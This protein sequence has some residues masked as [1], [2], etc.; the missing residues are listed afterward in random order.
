MNLPDKTGVYLFKN[1]RG[2][3]IYVGKALSLRNRVRS[4]FQK[5]RHGGPK[6][7]AMVGH[8][9]EVDYIVTGSEVEAL[10]L[11]NSL[12]KQY[13]PRYN[14]HLKDDKDYPYLKL[15]LE[16]EY[17]RLVLTRKLEKDGSRYFGP[18]TNV[19]A[20]RSTLKT[21]KKIFP[22]RSCQ[23]EVSPGSKERP[24]LN[25]HMHYCFAPCRGKISPE[26]YQ[27]LAKDLIL[28]LEGRQ[29]KLF[30]KMEKDMKE[31]SEKLQFERAAALR[32]KF[33]AL[34][35]VVSRQKV[36]SPRLKDQD[37]VGYARGEGE[38]CLQ[39]LLIR[40]G[41]IV[42][43]EKFMLT[44]TRD[45]EEGEIL[46]VFLKQYY[47]SSS[48]LP[49]E[50]IVP[51]EIEDREVLESWL[52]QR[53]GKKVS[54]HRPQRGLKKEILDM[55]MDNARFFLKA[56]KENMEKRDKMLKKLGEDLGIKKAPH[57]IEG[58]DVSNLYRKEIVASMVVFEDG[59][60]AKENYR[61]FKI[62]GFEKPD[63][64]KALKEALTRRLKGAL[65]E[66][67]EI[68]EGFLREDKTK[69]LPLPDLVIIDGGKGQLKGAGEV[70]KDLGVNNI[71]LISLA[72]GEE[73]I[74]L[75]GQREPLVLPRNSSTLK[76]IQQ[77]R[78]EAHRFALAYHRNLRD[79][80]TVNSLLEEIPGIGKKRQKV[81]LTYF[82]SLEKIRKASR[83]ELLQ[84]PG[85]DK[86][87]AETVY[88]HFQKR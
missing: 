48:F 23:G 4:Y 46:T 8:V 71:S 19:T 82:G 54:F 35:G 12:I 7:E 50:I 9:E 14:A 6:V 33:L 39:V 55:A 80:D 75:P 64:Y 49:G 3:V 58:F 34:Q 27:K 10:I 66:E 74:F 44:K 24:C 73:Y 13:K 15:T 36:V 60:P 38:S 26:A 30:K 76:L 77:V 88:Y 37:V 87:T 70:L 2:E 47:S 20:L 63:D 53:K 41:K 31:A 67:G 5:S 68:K 29:E 21:L 16:E 79:R 17:P 52:S 65:R 43:K 42:G 18:Y 62:E 59:L 85:L 56:E 32:D 78:D 72:K 84:V 61:R 40:E 81:L 86:K 83:E 57:R 22:L 51:L 69:F 45:M 11:E 28:F 1:K 25:Y